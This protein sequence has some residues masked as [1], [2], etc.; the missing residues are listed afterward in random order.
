MESPRKTRCATELLAPVT[1]ALYEG[2]RTRRASPRHR[3]AMRLYTSG[4]VPTKAAAADA[5]GLS[6]SSFYLMTMPSIVNPDLGRIQDALD[7]RIQNEAEDIAVVLRTVGREAVMEIRKV[8]KQG[9]NEKLR[10]EAAKD[11]ADRSTETSK[12]LKAQITTASLGAADAKELAAALV[13]AAKS[14]AEY[15]AATQGNFVR[16]EMGAPGAP[17]QLPKPVVGELPG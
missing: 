11:L 16:V 12:I 14:Q 9:S 10:L 5:A 15:R 2:I 13:E 8:M 6:R 4:L 3:L 1:R 17:A 7:L